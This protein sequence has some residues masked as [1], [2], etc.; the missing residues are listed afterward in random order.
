MR[1]TSRESV[2]KSIII[3]YWWWF[4]KHQN[5]SRRGTNVV[6]VVVVVAVCDDVYDVDDAKRQKQKYIFSIQLYLE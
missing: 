5:S 3:R 1:E 4:S 6:V 2:P